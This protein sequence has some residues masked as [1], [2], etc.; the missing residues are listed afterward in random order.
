MFKRNKWNV[1]P[2]V[3]LAALTLLSAC[4]KKTFQKQDFSTTALAG[5]YIY[6]KPKLDL[7]IFQDNS[8]SMYNALGQFK[9]QLQDFL[10]QLDTNWEYR[11]V[12]LPL[13]FQQSM[14]SKYVIA[15]DCSSV[16]G[17]GRCLS[18]SEVGTFNSVY[19]DAGW[20]L[21]DNTQTGNSDL[22]FY[23]M[24]Y[25]INNLIGS[26]FLRPDA[27]KSFMVLSN[28]ED[29]TNVA[30]LRRVDGAITS[31]DYNS[32]TTIN[33]FNAYKNYFMS[34]K[35]SIALQKFYS[36]VSAQ[37]Y[38]DCWGGG[39]TWQGKRYMDM[40]SALGGASYDLCG[41]GLSSVLNDIHGSLQVV[42]QTVEFNFVV[43][44]PTDEPD[45]STIVLK[46]NG[47]TIPQSATNGWTYVGLQTNHPTSDYPTIGSNQTGYMVQLNGTAK[48]KGSDSIS[49]SYLKK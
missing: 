7:V 22:G 6:I 34:L 26:G 25:N 42:V 40:A 44:S 35:S 24:N 14:S 29:N 15:T 9:P 16:T 41:G 3:A 38:S 13:L 47:V 48:F 45:P 23:N 46:K 19:G 36:V 8:D 18:P 1:V 21:T 11:V 43:I 2:A 10:S 37:R 12:V 4:G 30:Y 28:G 17:V 27:L 20:I 5:Q 33:S 31:I 32:P 49:I 39:M